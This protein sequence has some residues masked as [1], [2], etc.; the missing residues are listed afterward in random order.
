MNRTKRL[1]VRVPRIQVRGLGSANEGT[2]ELDVST[3]EGNTDVNESLASELSSETSSRSTIEIL[4]DLYDNAAEA[5]RE[6]EHKKLADNLEAIKQN[7]ASYFFNKFLKELELSVGIDLEG[8][9]TAYIKAVLNT[10]SYIEYA[11][12]DTEASALLKEATF[13]HVVGSEI[14]LGTSLPYAGNIG[15]SLKAALAESIAVAVG[16]N[17]LGLSEQLMSL[18]PENLSACFNYGA[19][20]SRDLKEDTLIGISKHLVEGVVGN[21]DLADIYLGELREV[22]ESPTPRVTLGGIGLGGSDLRAYLDEYGIN[23]DQEFT[24]VGDPV[25]EGTQGIEEAA[26]QVVMRIGV[27]GESVI[28]AFYDE[29]EALTDIL[30]EI[31]SAEVFEKYKATVS[32]TGELIV[33]VNTISN[34][35][36]NELD[37]VELMC[38][39]AAIIADV[40]SEVVAESG[41]E[42]TLQ[43]LAT[44]TQELFSM[45]GLEDT[46]MSVAAGDK[47]A[48]SQSPSEALMS[49]MP[50]VAKKV[51]EDSGQ[52]VSMLNKIV[53]KVQDLASEGI[54]Y[55]EETT[56]EQI[57]SDESGAV[58]KA[59]KNI[60]ATKEAT[61]TL[62]D[63]IKERQAVVAKL[64]GKSQVKKP[65]SSN[66][67]LWT[68]GIGGLLGGAYLW[69]RHNKGNN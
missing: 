23:E 65:E 7:A 1:T 29:L 56:A 64:A 17:G 67:L 68:L 25:L 39:S 48:S 53:R 45:P 60:I 19:S 6:A 35:L 26:R 46:I 50:E 58:K 43:S 55:L 42:N 5:F 11:S 52:Q 49:V 38:T 61:K 36:E 4:Y 31:M 57:A 30:S 62:V 20:F 41:F 8:Y 16:A 27:V 14:R 21:I 40:A 3:Q 24:L 32:A 51:V 22:I 37:A 18:D 59:T 2:A 66:A 9:L 15:T 69:H 44:A 10:D 28:R 12:T 54:K 47:E 33:D 13:G 34:E 63:R